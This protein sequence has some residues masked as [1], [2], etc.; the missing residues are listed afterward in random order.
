MTV[1]EAIERINQAGRGNALK[2]AKAV[3]RK[4]PKDERQMVRGDLEE[5]AIAID[6]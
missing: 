3:I 1:D 4:I 6:E 5:M 2:E